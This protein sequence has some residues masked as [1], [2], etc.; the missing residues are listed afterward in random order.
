[1]RTLHTSHSSTQHRLP[2]SCTPLQQMNDATRLQKTKVTVVF[3]M[4]HSATTR[5]TRVLFRCVYPQRHILLH[6]FKHTH[7][8]A[9]PQEVA[10]P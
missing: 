2:F 7:K 8:Y 5:R 6:L 9:Q 10:Q 3:E 4:L 1:M